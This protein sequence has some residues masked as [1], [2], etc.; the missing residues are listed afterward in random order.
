MITLLHSSKVDDLRIIQTIAQQCEAE[1][2]CVSKCVISERL[3]VKVDFLLL[4]SI[5]SEIARKDWDRSC[6]L[7]I[8]PTT[9]RYK[10]IITV[11]WYFIKCSICCLACREMLVLCLFKPN[12]QDM[13]ECLELGVFLKYCNSYHGVS[14]GRWISSFG[15]S[16]NLI[17]WVFRASWR[18]QIKTFISPREGPSCSGAAR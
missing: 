17:L 2:V 10:T 7:H 9:D 16:R 18:V 13:M 5:R 6:S 8:S 11:T 12:H 14:W 4:M 1:C 15:R 3:W